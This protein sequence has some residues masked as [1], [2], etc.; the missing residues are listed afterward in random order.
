MNRGQT[1]I[2]RDDIKGCILSLLR[3]NIYV[4]KMFQLAQQKENGIKFNGIPINNLR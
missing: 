4:E 2:S 1:E 3:F